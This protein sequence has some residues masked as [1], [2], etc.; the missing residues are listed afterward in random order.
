MPVLYRKVGNVTVG[1]LAFLTF[2]VYT[3]LYLKFTPPRSLKY[4][5]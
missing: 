3:L 2:L 4:S 5:N 1:V